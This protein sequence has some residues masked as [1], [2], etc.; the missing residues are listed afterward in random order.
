[1]PTAFLFILFNILRHLNYIYTCILSNFFE[2]PR[3]HRTPSWYFRENRF[4]VLV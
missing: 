4:F 3:P 1:L 2:T